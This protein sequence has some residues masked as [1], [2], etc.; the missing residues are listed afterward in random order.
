M[1][2]QVMTELGLGL[3]VDDDGLY[4]RTLQRS[5][6]RA[7]VDTELATSC[8]EALDR[9]H[10]VLP[11]FA[12]IDLRIGKE[13]GLTLIAPLRELR[14]DMKILLVTGYASVATA[15]EAIKRGADDYLPKPATVE[16]I[17]RAL[18]DGERPVDSFETM[19]P[20]RRVEWEHVQQALTEASGN[21]SAAARLLGIHRRS[22]QRKLTK[23]PRPERGSN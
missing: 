16:A 23:R 22:L 13:S 6:K 21:I 8:A 14:A 5:M 20:L 2:P 11:S 10:A 12:L 1:S 15:V 4:L 18:A 19:T 17:L 7:G 9:A 3:L